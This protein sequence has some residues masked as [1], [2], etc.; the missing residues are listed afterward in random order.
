MW[1]RRPLG[2]AFVPMSSHPP[3]SITAS[4]GAP[5]A[6]PLAYVRTL[7]KRRWL[8]ALFAGVGALAAYGWTLKQPRVYEADCTLEYDPHPPRPL[9]NEFT[10]GSTMSWWDTR[11]FFAT[12]NRI[13]SSRSV[14][15]KVIRKLSLHQNAEFMSVPPEKRSAWKGATVSDAAQ[16]LQGLITVRPERETRIVHVLARGRDPERAQLLANSI[17]DSY[18]EKTMED[19]LSAT[20]G[21]LEWLGKH[22]DSLKS[23]LEN[24]ELELHEFTEQHSELAVSLEDQQGIVS[25]N[26]QQI[27]DELTLTKSKRIALAARLDELVAANVDDPLQVHATAVL[28]NDAMQSLRERYRELLTER[29]GLVV[30]YGDKHPKLLTVDSQ[31]STV[32]QEMRREI[33]SLVASARGDLQEVERVE[34]GLQRALDQ[35]NG[36][37]LELNLQE[38]TFRRLQRNRDNTS[39]LYG[40][41]LERTAQTDLTRALSVTFVRVV[42]DALLPA[43]PVS[44]RMSTNLALGTMLGLLLGLGLAVLLEQL[45]RTVRTV[46]DAEAVGVTVLGVMPKIGEG[47]SIATPRYGRRKGR[48][49]PMLAG[50]RDLVVHTHPK[51]SAAECC[52]TIRTNLTFMSADTPRKMIVVTSASPREGKTT[53]SLSLAIALAQGGK[54]VLIVDTD[55]RKPRIHRTFESST[56]RGV[57]TVLVG[58]HS[59]EEAIQKT[60]VPNLD[61]LTSG[62]I[63]PNPSELLHTSQ[64]RDLLASLSRRYDQVIFDSPP[65]AAVTDAAI[66]APQVDGAI[67]VIHGRKTSRDALRSSLRQLRDVNSHVIGGVLNDIDLSAHPTGYGSYYYYYRGDGY[68]AEDPPDHDDSEPGKPSIAHA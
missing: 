56:A 23:Q 37:G 49:E 29:D 39:K 38:I 47:S 43:A 52:R 4:T 58:E 48:I 35:A 16:R 42:D 51:S 7:W 46:E 30:H 34:K 11:E 17:A 28:A 19:Q 20:T 36:V 68:Q 50:N 55:L 8:I 33:D 60:P 24:T 27:S 9:G 44:P 26:I 5:E 63:P 54:R 12:Q 22:L 40:T 13:I 64:F 15:E 21:A 6:R 1:A 66:I 61:V 31:M 10:E 3:S 18:I 14:A 62:P 25:R 45:D 2:L 53:V 59:L 41:L 65:L 32:R 57:T 67:L